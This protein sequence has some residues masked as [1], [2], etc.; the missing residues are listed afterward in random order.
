[1]FVFAY[2]FCSHIEWISMFATFSFRLSSVK[3]WNIIM[4]YKDLDNHRSIDEITSL[5]ISGLSSNEE[6][7]RWSYSN[8]ESLSFSNWKAGAQRVKRTLS[9]KN[10]VIVDKKR[11]WRNKI[12]SKR[13]ARFICEIDIGAGDPS[14]SPP[15]RDISKSRDRS[16]DRKRKLNRH[17]D[18][19]N[20][21]VRQ[22]NR[23]KDSKRFG[24]TSSIWTS[25]GG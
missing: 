14:R 9:K 24:R 4:Q 17:R 12:C 16:R 11:K 1:M 10:C 15:K 6:T 22:N 5:L 3:Y 7:G 20:D 8:G 21:E 2:Y 19:Q 13:K 18:R 25:F 23:E